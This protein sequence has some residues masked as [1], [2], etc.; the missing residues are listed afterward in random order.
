[1]GKIILA[2]G[3]TYPSFYTF[4]APWRSL[5]RLN[6]AWDLGKCDAHVD[7][8]ARVVDNS[9]FLMENDKFWRKRN[10]FLTRVQFHDFFFFFYTTK[11]HWKWESSSFDLTHFPGIPFNWKR[12]WFPLRCRRLSFS[13]RRPVCVSGVRESPDHIW[14]ELRS[15]SVCKA[16]EWLACVGSPEL[17]HWWIE[18]R[19]CFSSPGSHELRL[20]HSVLVCCGIPWGVTGNIRGRRGCFDGGGWVPD[21]RYGWRSG[22]Q[23]APVSQRVCV[24]CSS[25]LLHQF[26]KLGAFILKP[27]L[28]LEKKRKKGKLNRASDSCF[29]Y[30]IARNRI[31]LEKNAII[32]F[33]VLKYFLETNAWYNVDF[34][35]SMRR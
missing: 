33:Y 14:S 32:N 24:Y 18:G 9:N 5:K 19:G 35:N 12:D 17:G 2:H 27:D 31:E 34:K 25:A 30:R 6:L 8:T 29:C 3:V 11:S 21:R 15:A 20:L 23:S 1:M 26:L 28:H 13:P 4:T 16:A 22:G 7:L 10:T